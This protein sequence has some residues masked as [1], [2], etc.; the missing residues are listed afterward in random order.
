MSTTSASSR[1]NEL[2]ERWSGGRSA[3]RDKSDEHTSSKEPEGAKPEEL[4]APQ[5]LAEALKAAIC[6]NFDEKSKELA[7]ALGLND[8]GA[9]MDASTLARVFELVQGMFPAQGSVSPEAR[10]EY[11][12]RLATLLDELEDL[13]EGLDVAATGP[14]G[15]A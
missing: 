4:V 9:Q 15:G 13:L 1:L 5:V 12:K 6:A 14:G 3:S 7:P 11:R 10:K 8:H 2:V